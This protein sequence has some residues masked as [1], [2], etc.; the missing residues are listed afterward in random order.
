MYTHIRSYSQTWYTNR[1]AKGC[2][3]Y[4]TN[5]V[6]PQIAGHTGPRESTYT[7][8]LQVTCHMSRVTYPIVCPT[9]VTY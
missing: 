7:M 4:Y 5:E 9:H 1:F 8:S 3:I 2:L 6:Y